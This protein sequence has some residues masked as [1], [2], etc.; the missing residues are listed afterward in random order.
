M[1]YLVMAF[2]ALG[3]IFSL[4]SGNYVAAFWAVAVFSSR[5]EVLAGS[6]KYAALREAGKSL[7]LAGLWSTPRLTPDQQREMWVDFRDKLGLPAGT[8]TKTGV[9][10]R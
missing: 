1:N 4:I 8:A 3:A 2:A 6:A 7:Y 10:S 9:E 5:V